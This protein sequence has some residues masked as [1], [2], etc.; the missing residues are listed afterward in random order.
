MTI[1]QRREICPFCSLVIQSVGSAADYN[2]PGTIVQNA[3]CYARWEVDEREASY[4][5][6]GQ[7]IS[8]TRRIRVVWDDQRLIDS[9][10]VLVS[11]E[12]YWTPNSDAYTT[13]S[14]EALFLGRNIEAKFP[15][16]IWRN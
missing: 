3:R 13:W 6:S 10:L 2:I 11:P 12:R 4:T 8:R 5:R 15:N 7:V 14:N 9:Y 1:Q 16:L